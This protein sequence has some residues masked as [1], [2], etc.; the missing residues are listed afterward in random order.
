MQYVLPQ[1]PAL[2]WTDRD[3]TLHSPPSRNSE[4]LPW[5]LLRGDNCGALATSLCYGENRPPASRDTCTQALG[6]TPLLCIQ[7]Q[8]TSLRG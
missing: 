1:C 4:V 5:R 7:F 2:G 8:V 3:L 6:P